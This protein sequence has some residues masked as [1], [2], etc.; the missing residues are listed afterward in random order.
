VLSVNTS[1]LAFGALSLG[2]IRELS[3]T[4][5]NA[6]GGTLTGAASTTSPYT[7]VS[8]A[9]YS[10]AANQTQVVTV[11]F[12]P[13]ALGVAIRTLTLTGGQGGR[14]SLSGTGTAP[15]LRPKPP[16]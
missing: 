7:V 4:I 16:S 6:G 3:L 11:R 1:S 10:L 8:G 9:A 2:S 15:A 5:K 13:V 12:S 14:L